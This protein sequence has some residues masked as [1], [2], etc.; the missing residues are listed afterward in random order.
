M[1]QVKKDFFEYHHSM[2]KLFLVA[3]ISMAL[4]ACTSKADNAHEGH[5]H[6]DGQCTEHSHEGH[7][8]ADGQCAEHGH[9]VKV[10][11]IAQEGNAEQG[12][13]TIVKMHGGETATYDYSKSNPDK[14]A[15]WIPGDTVTIF[16]DHHHHGNH[17]HESVTAVKIGDMGC[18]HNHEGHNH[19]H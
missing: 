7:N 10:V 12:K 11:G 18:S 14:I 3:A 5:N 9:T 2:K 1:R 19:E 4:A 16:I 15:A 17:H 13:I 6:A 8:H